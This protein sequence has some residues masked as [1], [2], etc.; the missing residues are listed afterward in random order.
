MKN[1]MALGKS[2]TLAATIISVTGCSI[3]QSKPYTQVGSI[4]ASEDQAQMDSMKDT[5]GIY[6]TLITELTYR[7]NVDQKRKQTSAVY[8]AL[9]SD[10]GDV[11]RWYEGDARGAVKAVHG[12]PHNSGVCRVIYSAIERKGRTRHF[13]ETACRS[14]TQE[15]WKFQAL[16]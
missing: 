6:A 16:D 3:N 2:L 9:E 7:L 11:Y 15:E 5:F 10:Y 12:Y 4:R 8:A 1:L 14:Y 13:K